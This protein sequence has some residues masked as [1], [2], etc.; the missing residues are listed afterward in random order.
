MSM[1]KF[2]VTPIEGTVTTPRGFRAAG[3]SCGI[4]NSKPDLALVYSERPASAAGTFTQNKM[5]S[6]PVILSE[7]RLAPGKAQA[8]VVNSGN[9]NACTGARGHE[10]ARRMTKAAAGALGI[11]EEYV[12][13][14]STGVI[15]RPLP[16]EKIEGAMDALVAA[17]GSDGMSAAKAIMTTDAFTKTAAAQVEI[18]DG[19]VKVGGIAKGA[20]MIHPNMATMIAIMTT[21]ALIEPAALRVMLKDVVNRTFNRISV[22]GDTSTSDTVVLFANGASG[23]RAVVKGDGRYEA[24]QEALFSVASRLAKLIVQDGEG[25]TRIVEVVVRAAATESDARLAVDAV[26]TSLLVKTALHGAEL[27]WGRIAA[28]LGRSGAEV[29][30]ER[31]AISIGGHLVV[32]DGIGVPAGY[33]AAQEE[34]CKTEVGVV[35]DLGLGE[36]TY[37]RVT[38]DLSEAYVKINSGYLT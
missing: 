26:V 29:D 27:N 30:P 21:D 11:P 13:V 35:V 16:V 20:G 14:A 10:D 23:T 33:A 31:L 6:A 36:G 3:I 17:L 24:V 12:L 9:S 32:K 8:M 4:K 15:G 37:S 2:A 18:G 1:P 5:R 25:T 34:I 7:A 28:A 22:D 19:E 38:G